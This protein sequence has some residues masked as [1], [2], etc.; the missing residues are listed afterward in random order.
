MKCLPQ[1]IALCFLLSRWLNKPAGL[2]SGAGGKQKPG[3]SPRHTHTLLWFSL[4]R[5]G[6][7][8]GIILDR[9]G[10]SNSYYRRT[11]VGCLE[12]I[13]LNAL[14]TRPFV[15]Q[16]LEQTATEQSPHHCHL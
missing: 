12:I 15:V 7:G 2:L 10:Q 16:D 13:G 9:A 5:L 3:I 11:C 14:P 4:E 8:F 6:F 1:C